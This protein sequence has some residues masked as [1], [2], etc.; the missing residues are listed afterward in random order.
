MFEE[1][2]ALVV[3]LWRHGRLGEGGLDNLAEDIGHQL[4]A[5]GDAANECQS[6][7]V[8]QDL[9]KDEDCE[10]LREI[11][12]NVHD[13][14]AQEDQLSVQEEVDHVGIIR[15]DE[16]SNHTQA[17]QTQQLERILFRY[18]VEDGEEE[19]DNAG[20]NFSGAK[21]RLEGL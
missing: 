19:H 8:R 21:V 5:V 7:V 9:L 3:V 15:L 4:K 18:R 11:E 14:E 17:G 12:A 10:G 2:L 13:T 20:F 6:R 1:S 16:G